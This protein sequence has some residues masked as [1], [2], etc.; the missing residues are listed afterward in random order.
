M[1]HEVSARRLR[2]AR[3][4]SFFAHCFLAQ[5]ANCMRNLLIRRS[6]LPASTSHRLGKISFI[7][8]RVMAATP[9]PLPSVSSE[10]VAELLESL[11]EIRS[12]VKTASSS[13]IPR[14]LVAVSKYKP[15]SD[16]SVCYE[17]GQRDF[18]ENYVQE[19]VDKAQQVRPGSVYQL[20]TPVSYEGRYPGSYP[21]TY[22]GI[23]SGLYSP[24]KPRSLQVRSNVDFAL[25][26]ITDHH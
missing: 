11:G 22:D 2:G 14:T 17:D 21:S 18:G 23:S 6:V 1:A 8:Y 24:I 13:T 16:I 12:R 25:Y 7:G 26:P 19:L 10:R 3:D 9:T 4:R 5:L 15:A 20:T